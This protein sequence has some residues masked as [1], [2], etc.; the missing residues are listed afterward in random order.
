MGTTPAPLTEAALRA[1][2]AAHVKRYGFDLASMDE[3]YHP[4]DAIAP[5]S[6]TCP[7]TDLRA[8]EK[9]RLRKL[10]E[11]GERTAQARARAIVIEEAV[12][13]ALAFAAQYPDAP[14]AGAAS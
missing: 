10:M 8:S 1:T 5:L 3:F 11:T 7:W 12:A 14:R 9:R 13:A 4:F 6:R 2:I